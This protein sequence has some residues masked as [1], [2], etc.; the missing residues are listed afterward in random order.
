MPLAL[1]RTPRQDRSRETLNRL[2]DAGKAVAAEQG[3]EGIVLADVLARARCSVG[4]FY[5]R[6]PSR[7]AFLEAVCLRVTDE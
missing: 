7:D 5:A 6:F 1:D 3:F 2:L 4:S